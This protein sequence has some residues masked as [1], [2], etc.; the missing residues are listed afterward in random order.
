M[1]KQYIKPEMEVILINPSALLAGSMGPNG[2]QDPTMAP[3]FED[4]FG[5]FPAE[6]KPFLEF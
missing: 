1:K 2:Q 4:E 5:I 6:L 3:E